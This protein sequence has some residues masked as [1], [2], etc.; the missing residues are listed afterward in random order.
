MRSAAPLERLGVMLEAFVLRREA[1][2]AHA[3]AEVG[4]VVDA[5]GAGHDFLAAHEEVVG[6]C[7]GRVV[8]GGVRVE[9]AEGARVLVDGVEVRVVLFEDYFA[10]GFFLCG[11]WRAELVGFF[12][13]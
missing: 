11:A 1:L 2:C 10:E 7:E 4:V 8:G 5:L 12:L 13:W 6:V 3:S 9:G